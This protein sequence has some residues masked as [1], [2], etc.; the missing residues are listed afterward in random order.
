VAVAGRLGLDDRYELLAETALEDAGTDHVPFA[1]AGVPAISILHFPYEEY[2][3][4]EDS[5][6]LVDEQ[7]IADAVALAA[8]IVEH[9]LA[10]PRET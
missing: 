3:L 4:P 2:H 5:L 6:E 8:E 9:L 10:A 1:A 7:L